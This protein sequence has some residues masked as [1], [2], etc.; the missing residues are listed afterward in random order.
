[1]NTY[2]DCGFYVGVALHKLVDAGIIDDTW[3]IYAFEPSLQF[4]VEERLKEFNL[5]IELIRKAVWI[6]DGTVSFQE[7]G[8]ENANFVEGTSYSG[9]PIKR[10]KIPSVDFSKFVAELPR[11]YIYCSMD[12]EGS[13]FAVL[14]KM[15]KDNTINRINVLDI[16]FHHRF[17]RD[18][19]DL[20]A[21]E[22]IKQIKAR[23]VEIKLKEA[24]V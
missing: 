12:I 18:Y 2:L 16:E 10:R 20:D 8:R 14:E 21:R 5:D 17:M 1:M 9:A 7:S 13:E 22:L 24:L 11:G 6:E 23:G 4:K 19:T 15:L 3:K